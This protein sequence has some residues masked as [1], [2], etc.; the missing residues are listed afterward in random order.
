MPAL[1]EMNVLQLPHELGG[2]YI[3]AW[4][5]TDVD[6]PRSGLHRRC[7]IGVHTTGRYHSIDTGKLTMAPL[8]AAM[9]GAR[10]DEFT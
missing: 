6:D 3:V 10:V 7:D 1:A 4:G 8:N 9:L 2:G 5:Q